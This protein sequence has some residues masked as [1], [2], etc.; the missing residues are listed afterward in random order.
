MQL[1]FRGI[2]VKSAMKRLFQ[3][4]INPSLIKLTGKSSYDINETILISGSPRSGTTWVAN[5]LASVTGATTL[6]E[7][8][9]PVRVPKAKR[10][11]LDWRTYVS[12]KTDWPNGRDFFKEVLTGKVINSWT[13]SF[14]PVKSAFFPKRWI[15]KCV[16]A[17][18]LLPWLT[19]EYPRLPIVYIVRHPCAT[20]ASQLRQNW[21][22]MKSPPHI[23]GLF[24][25]YPH[26]SQIVERLE[27]PLEYTAAL[28]CLENY[29]PLSIA[30]REQFLTVC[31]EEL[32]TDGFNVVQ[33]MGYHV[34]GGTFSSA[35]LNIEQ[36]SLSSK[37]YSLNITRSK[38][39][40]GWQDLLNEKE[41][42]SVLGVVAE[43]G[44]GLYGADT[45]PDMSW[46][47]RKDLI[48]I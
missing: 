41:I 32:V 35:N 42:Q 43:F 25:E 3:G 31:Y 19:E 17:N 21:P 24:E 33:K 34:G 18:L 26:L 6:F 47:D 38:Q 37:K 29:V 13:T 15:V 46:L 28:W 23:P 36:R 30:S 14:S 48:M 44:I 5:L 16:R 8:L 7:P 2:P 4:A 20:I 1:N 9:H 27:T 10:A 45:T 11:G 39:L 40:A 22:L 12:A